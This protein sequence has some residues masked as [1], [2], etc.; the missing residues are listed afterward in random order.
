M[1]SALLKLL[2]SRGCSHEFSWPRR[3]DDDTYYQVCLRCG[4]EYGYDWNSMQRRERIES[5]SRSTERQPSARRSQWV[6]RAR[7]LY[8]QIPLKYRQMGIEDWCSAMVRNISQSGLMFET[9]QLLPASIDLEMIF[10]MPLEITGQPNSRVFCRG[11]VKRSKLSANQP[12]VSQ[13]G[14]AISGYSFLHPEE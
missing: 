3:R 7:R 13:I 10:E 9:D 8:V 4:V 5:S 14:V 6:P 2:G 12:T 11:Q 1:S